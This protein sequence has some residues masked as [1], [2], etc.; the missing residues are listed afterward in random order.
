MSAIP[1]IDGARVYQNYSPEAAE[2]SF[3]VI[4]IGSGMGGMT[5]AAALAHYDRKVLL[6]EQHYVPGG[7]THSFAR[8]GFVWDAG[9]HAIGEMLPHELPAKILAWLTRGQVEMVPLGDPYDR[10]SFHDGFDWGLP[11]NRERWVQ[12]LYKAFPDQRAAIDKYLQAVKEATQAAVVFF[13]M[14]SLPAGVEQ[15]GS[16]ALDALHRWEL[17]RGQESPLAWWRFTTKQV[18]DRAGV[19][20]KLRTLLTL[21]WGYYGST[22]SQSAFPIHALTHSHFWNG[23]YYPKGG[24][25]EL[26]AQLLD[27]VRGAGGK[28]LVRARVKE[29]LVEDGRAQGVVMEDGHTI[30][31]RRVVSAVGAK[32]TVR[33][34]VPAALRRSAWGD[35][36]LALPDS[37]PYICLNLGFEGD[38]QGAG[39][40][41]S[42]QWFFETWD[43]EAALWDVKDPNSKAPILYCSFPSLKDPLH[44]PGRRQRH[45]GECVTFVDWA[46]F[47]PFKDSAHKERP[48]D[49]E[50]LK[51]DI[52]ARLLAHLKERLPELMKLMVHYELST[53]LTTT[54][55]AEASH[56]A[57]YGLAATPKR[58]TTRALRTRTPLPGFYLSGVDVAAIGV[59]GA[60]TSGM[61]TA[62]ALE[63]RVYRHLL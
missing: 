37:P 21:H 22:P 18:L 2:G 41:A 46:L 28:A 24:S 56:G 34:L 16:R 32:S 63:P 38:I 52:E 50:A 10:F 48:E 51:R 15:V 62:A 7:F 59:V 8:K 31:A 12:A 30:R 19:R 13:G 43:T 4:V 53:P 40:A 20:G 47:E 27:V 55:F 33:S 3:D 25:K 1:T 44:D 36:I 45:T 42:N 26:A 49:Y 29:I 54:H 39:A 60:M 23:A 11:A 14:K 9:V 61:L 57:I 35:A 17:L 6:L 58:F 5:C